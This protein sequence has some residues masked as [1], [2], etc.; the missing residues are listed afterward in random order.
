M[1][2]RDPVMDETS[3]RTTRWLPAWYPLATIA[4]P[5]ERPSTAAGQ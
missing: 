2:E 5:A 1:T 3:L 4:A